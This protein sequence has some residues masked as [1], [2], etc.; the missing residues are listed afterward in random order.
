MRNAVRRAIV[1][2]ALGIASLPAAALAASYPAGFYEE[3]AIVLRRQST[4]ILP[5][6][7]DM[8]LIAEKPGTVVVAVRG[9][10]KAQL[11][12]IPVNNDLERG[13][14]GLA[15]EPGFTRRGYL[16]VYYTAP[17][18]TPLNR[19]SRFFVD[20]KN[21]A[22]PEEILLDGIP[23]DSGLHNG[24]CLRFGDDGHLY[25]GIG[26]GGA[27]PAGASDLSSLAGKILRLEPDGAIPADNPFVSTPGARPEIWA[28]GLRNP[29][30][31]SFDP[32][33]AGRLFAN[34][35]G[36]QTWEEVNDIRSGDSYGWP[37][38][39][40]PGGA[41]CCSDPIA[42]YANSGGAA[43][44]GSAFYRGATYPPDL[45]GS[46]FYA[47]FVTGA[48]RRLI[49]A[50][51]GSVIASETFATGL[52]SPIDLVAAPDG[53][54]YYLSYNA[55]IVYRIRYVGSGNR[56]PALALAASPEAGRAPLIVTFKMTGSYDPD[57]DPLSFRLDY[58]DG[59]FDD[60]TALSISHLFTATR[61][62]DV[63]V[64]AFDGRGGETTSGIRI[65]AGNAYPVPVI[66][67]PADRRTYAC[68]DIINYAGSATD[69]EDG[70][71]PAA[72]LTWTI[73][74][75]HDTHGHPFLGPLDGIAGGQFTIPR[76]GEHATNVAYKIQLR[77]TDSGGLAQKTKVVLVPRVTSFEILTSPLPLT[78][79]VAGTPHTAPAAVDSVVGYE[80]TI[81]VPTP[82]VGS[83]G[84]TYDFFQWAD[85][86][87]TDNPR[88]LRAP[89]EPSEFLAIFLRRT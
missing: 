35:V 13:L 43:V 59:S 82:Q 49:L 28:Y 14:L 18:P 65:E 29:Y 8:F 58:D 40:G 17:G 41:G 69:L 64:T 3:P 60:T 86:G 52:A 76:T 75:L 48:L 36:N 73:S 79:E 38:Y 50:G 80:W 88:L 57:G 2:A 77:A 53:D 27:N 83:D 46:Y 12:S 9:R 47:D 19:V 63:T 51:D 23:S 32:A 84:H 55:K 89:E 26:D 61:A 44:T 20:G 54:F 87:L 85:S 30:R 62:H 1:A 42:Y 68:G 6:R 78:V 21:G 5:V 24:G 22:G 72:A 33:V 25:V 81:S 67:T 7:R 56:P 31:F 4:T 10:L 74:F 70:P 39:E 71:L 15:L 37:V 16:Y 45:V 66:A 11:L 34:D